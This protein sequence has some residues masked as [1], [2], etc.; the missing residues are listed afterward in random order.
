MV[1][2][3]FWVLARFLWRHRAQHWMVDATG[4]GRRPR[5]LLRD[6]DAVF[7]GAFGSRL[8]ALGIEQLLLRAA[9]RRVL[10]HDGL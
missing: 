10:G 2:K 3:V 6:R 8:A 9:T 5:F 1:D 7:G 4:W